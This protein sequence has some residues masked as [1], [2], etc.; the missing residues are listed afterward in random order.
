VT[1]FAAAS[2]ALGI[3]SEASV[4]WALA[5]GDEG[6]LQYR[7]KELEDV[8]SR[9]SSDPK[10]NVLTGEKYLL[11][12]ETK[13]IEKNAAFL[14][15]KRSDVKSGGGFIQHAVL[16]VRDIDKA[17]TF[18]TKGIGMSVNRERKTPEG[19]R[20]VFVS[21]GPETLNVGDGGM[22]SLELTENPSLPAEVES[23]SFFFQ[24]CQTNAVRV[25]KLYNAG[26]EIVSGYGWFD[27]LAPEGHKVRVYVENRRDP[28]E[29]I[30]VRVKASTLDQ[31]VAFYERT[32]GMTADRSYGNVK[33]GTFEPPREEGSVLMTYGTPSDNTGI[34]LIPQKEVDSRPEVKVAVLTDDVYKREKNVTSTTSSVAGAGETAFIG[35]V[36]GPFLGNSGTKIA[37]VKPSAG[38]LVVP[39]VIFVDYEDFESEQPAPKIQPITKEIQALS[40]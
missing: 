6:I 5:K 8:V 32:C 27:I 20:V 26:G 11:E 28:F 15:A 9:L 21:F 17:V 38:T 31:A 18:W 19:K 12:S 3:A 1:N 2:I 37:V 13:R 22:F 39:P 40:G 25:S 35:S 30:G 4:S 14:G 33:V 7:K 24:I 23:R 16:E 10:N 29:L 34:L 36:P